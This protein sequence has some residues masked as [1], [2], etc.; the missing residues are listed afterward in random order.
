MDARNVGSTGLPLTRIGLGLAALGRPGYINVGHAAD[1]AGD[2]AVGA[3]RDHAARVLDAAWDAGIRYVD[4]ARSYGRAEEFLADWLRTRRRQI[5]DLSVGSKWGYTYTAGWAVDADVHEV[6]DHTLATL[7]RQ[8]TETAR[9]LN[10]WPGLYQIHSATIESGVLDRDDVLDALA[11]LRADRGWA[12][13]LTLSGTTSRQTLERSIDI[14]RDGMRLFDTV[15]ATW[16]LLEPSLSDILAAAHNDGMGVIVKEALANGRLTDRNDDPAFASR[17]AILDEQ[18]GRLGC[19]LDQLALAAV[20][21]QPWA[22]CVLS[23]AATDAQVRSNTAALLVQLDDESRA[24]L[25]TLVEEPADYWAN[26][27]ALPWG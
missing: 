18:A 1:L 27:S 5:G 4:T 12:I 22:D 19:G 7:Q 3:M 14:R 13:G 8:T 26:R 17:R 23:G 20:L 16:N 6:K 9:I 15:Q 21:D 11:L 10:G 25:A 2:Y 24:A